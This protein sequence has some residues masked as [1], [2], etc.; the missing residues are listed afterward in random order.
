[1]DGDSKIVALVSTVPTGGYR[2]FDISIA[3]DLL[4]LATLA[5]MQ[6]VIILTN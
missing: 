1:M 6:C 2:H 3:G 5:I 4:E